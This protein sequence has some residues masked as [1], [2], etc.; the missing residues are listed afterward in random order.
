MDCPIT[1]LIQNEHDQLLAELNS[2]MVCF[3]LRFPRTKP[4]PQRSHLLQPLPLTT[5]PY[6][7]SLRS[8]TSAPAFAEFEQAVPRLE[9]KLR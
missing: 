2:L 7:Q 3:E 9:F 6:L 4:P 1:S 5:P 8:D